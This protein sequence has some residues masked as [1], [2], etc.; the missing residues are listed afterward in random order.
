MTSPYR[1]PARD[2]RAEIV[3]P[4]EPLASTTIWLVWLATLVFAILVLVVESVNHLRIAWIALAFV[5]TGGLLL[6]RRHRRRMRFDLVLD[7]ETLTIARVVGGQREQVGRLHV[8]DGASVCVTEP[9]DS[10]D[11]DGLVRIANHHGNLEFQPGGH[12]GEVASEII[13]FLRANDID[14]PVRHK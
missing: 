9:P 2:A 6:L 5:T 8:A 1:T 7:G 13:R 4:S 10:T 3:V 11:F 12:T 14:V